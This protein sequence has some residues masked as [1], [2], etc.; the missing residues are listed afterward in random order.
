MLPLNDQFPPALREL[1]VM[2]CGFSSQQELHHQQSQPQQS[3]YPTT[4]MVYS[5]N[6]L[7]LNAPGIPSSLAPGAPVGLGPGSITFGK[8]NRSQVYPD[9]STPSTQLTQDPIYT[10]DIL[11]QALTAR[12]DQ[13]TTLCRYPIPP[14]YPATNLLSV[15]TCSRAAGLDNVAVGMRQLASPRY[16]S[17]HVGSFSPFSQVGSI[18]S[19][20]GEQH[21]RK[22]VQN[23]TDLAPRSLMNSSI[24]VTVGIANSCRISNP[25]RFTCN[26][27]SKDRRPCDICGDVSAG[28]HCNAY[29]CEA[30]KKFFIRSSKGDNFS[31]YTCTKSNACE[32]NKDTRTHCQRCRYQKCLR[33]GMVLPGAAV[34]PATD[35]SEIP[36]RVCGAKSSGFH[37][38]AIT[39]EGCKGFFRRTINERESQRYTCRNGGN[40]AVTGATRNNCKSCRYRRCV[41]VGMSKDGSRIGRQPNAVKHRCAIEIEQIRSA[42]ASCT[43]SYAKSPNK[44]YHSG[45]FM[46]TQPSGSTGNAEQSRLS[47]DQYVSTQQAYTN[48]SASSANATCL[49]PAPPNYSALLREG[50]RFFQSPT[51]SPIYLQ[52]RTNLVSDIC[53]SIPQSDMVPSSILES[54]NSYSSQ[55]DIDLTGIRELTPYKSCH[56]NTFETP[57]KHN[58]TGYVERADLLCSGQQTTQDYRRGFSN[59][60]AN[61]SSMETHQHLHLFPQ[62]GILCDSRIQAIR[63]Y[64]EQTPSVSLLQLSQAAQLCSERERQIGSGDKT[65]RSH[66]IEYSQTVF[67][68]HSPSGHLADE[69]PHDGR[70][71]YLSRAHPP[72]STMQTENFDEEMKPEEQTTVS[73]ANDL[74]HAIEWGVATNKIQTMNS[75]QYTKTPLEDHSSLNQ[76]V[77]CELKD[78]PSLKDMGCSEN[79]P[80]IG[81][82]RSAERAP[83]ATCTS[84]KVEPAEDDTYIWRELD[85]QGAHTGVNSSPLSYLDKRSAYEELHEELATLT[86]KA[87]YTLDPV[88]LEIEDQTK[89]PASSSIADQEERLVIVDQSDV[90]HDTRPLSFTVSHG[91]K[92]ERSPLNPQ[93]SPHPKSFISLRDNLRS[94]T[95]G[96]TYTSPSKAFLNRYTSTFHAS[97]FG[98]SDSL[99]QST[100]QYKPQLEIH[101]LHDLSDT[102]KVVS[103]L[104]ERSPEM[105]AHKPPNVSSEGRPFV[106]EVPFVDES[107]RSAIRKR[108]IT[109]E[110]TGWLQV[111]SNAMKASSEPTTGLTDLCSIGEFYEQYVGTPESSTIKQI[112]GRQHDIYLGMQSGK[113][114]CDENSPGGCIIS[115][116]RESVYREPVNTANLNSAEKRMQAETVE[117]RD[118][119]SDNHDVVLAEMSQVTTGSTTGPKSTPRQI[120]SVHS[121]AA[122]YSPSRGQSNLIGSPSARHKSPNMV[123]TANQLE[124]VDLDTDM[125]ELGAEKSGLQNQPTPANCS[126]NDINP[127][128]DSYTSE[129]C[130]PDMGVLHIPSG[131]YRFQRS[132]STYP[133]SSSSSTFVSSKSPHIFKVFDLKSGQTIPSSETIPTTSTS[134]VSSEHHVLNFRPRLSRPVCNIDA[135]ESYLIDQKNISDTV[136][137]VIY[138]HLAARGAMSLDMYIERITLAARNLG[139]CKI[140]GFSSFEMAPILTTD[141]VWSHMMEHFE[142]HAHQVIQ[143]ARAVPGFRD[144]PSVVM[145]KLVQEGMYPITMIQLSKDFQPSTMEYNYFNF[146]AQEREI[147]LRHFP[148]FLPVADQLRVAGTVLHPFNL[149]ETETALLCC[150][151]LFHG[152]GERF[153]ETS[154][155]ETMYQRTVSAL[156]TYE[157]TR[158]MAEV[159]TQNILAVTS[160]LTDMN[161]EHRAIV[162][163]LKRDRP[164]LK[165]PDLYVQM[166]ELDNQEPFDNRDADHPLLVAEP[167]ERSS[168]HPQN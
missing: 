156:R 78:D 65:N 56:S 144:L 88:R 6:I 50:S 45:T 163:T 98:D 74:W 77:T 161:E 52:A 119:I 64:G 76:D 132:S 154:K 125:L 8:V 133:S 17:E 150:I 57:A 39:C 48:T 81:S 70:G 102:R 94:T 11:E 141:I 108:K 42:V 157:E 153:G 37:F 118:R 35:I 95:S 107:K 128:M 49:R 16:G 47:G 66:M 117:V 111:T 27:G 114:K 113:H 83:P 160:L 43:T 105:I 59:S 31:K 136:T 166:F 15:P 159:R 26:L 155:V 69:A 167:N 100:A 19:A 165:F 90:N 82:Q 25:I 12:V 60:K 32:I 115:V 147:I 75:Y 112:D 10:A 121:D 120:Y 58:Q 21:P 89:T 3:L 61:Q 126:V 149:D 96:Q 29:V 72:V 164:S 51:E 24:P 71:Q 103:H 67:Q 152:G 137:D 73:V 46:S 148:D 30:C 142:A 140:W 131:Q 151:Q 158:Q 168:I 84:L 162:K 145:K 146:T 110:Q 106:S 23:E 101:K 122:I 63:E 36:C 93:L 34:F 53:P 123:I 1:D 104:S 9:S 54:I 79:R 40:C 14:N 127:Q 38:G 124:K 44:F 86:S 91:L 116:E 5:P 7:S 97:D 143:F 85:N 18:L 130:Y 62:E 134:I 4:P 2:L 138:S 68:S 41:A 135:V 20:N 13:T 55:A 92:S 80:R 28:F 22:L 129:S 33:L 109:E 139:R 99:V 87:A